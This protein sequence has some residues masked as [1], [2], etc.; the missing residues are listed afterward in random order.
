MS[1]EEN[2]TEVL[3]ALKLGL[4]RM[5]PPSIR[6]A[7]TDDAEFRGR[8][9]IT[10]DADLRFDQVGI[11]FRRSRLF[12]A[13]RRTY[14]GEDRVEIADKDGKNWSFAIETDNNRVRIISED[15][16][17]FLIPDF[18][19][20]SPRVQQRIEWFYREVH[21]TELLDS[22]ITSW[23]DVLHQRPA[24]DDEVDEILADFRDTPLSMIAALEDAFR[25]SSVSLSAL[26]PSS[27]RYYDR[28]I[29]AP[30]NCSTLKDFIDSVLA[31][32]FSKETQNEHFFKLFYLLASHPWVVDSMP[33]TEEGKKTIQSILGWIEGRSDRISQLGFIE[34][35]LQHIDE[36]PE[37]EIPLSRIIDDFVS[38]SLKTSDQKT[39]LLST[40]F[41][42]VDGELSKAGI[43]RDRPAFWRRL[44]SFAQASL[45]E[46]AAVSS[47]VPIEEFCQWVSDQGAVSFFVQTYV[48]MRTEPR[49]LPT[50]SSSK[51]LAT[52]FVAR[53]VTAGHKAFDKVKEAE[54]RRAIDEA[55]A[56]VKFPFSFLPG[57]LEGGVP[58]E[59]EIPQEIEEELRRAL[60]VPELSSSSFTVLVNAAIIYRVETSLA[61]LAADEL[62]RVKYQ[63]KNVS[64]AQAFALLSGLATVAAVTRSEQLAED[65]RVLMRV[66]RR[67]PGI[68]F[69]LE[70]AIHTALIS[71]GAFKNKLS[72][73][74][75]VGDC[76]TE[77]AL[78]DVTAEDALMLNQY[79]TILRRSEPTVGTSTARAAAACACF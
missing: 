41:V 71:A 34:W 19:C 12:G 21:S 45:I 44:A 18:S 2:G 40:L 24:T 68:K 75:F 26:V 20:L 31:A 23:R 50:F 6:S 9:G 67:T 55:R 15:G 32:R 8:L 61:V 43:C 39:T 33:I 5:F 48:D 72:W 7:A 58:P 38:D 78:G 25:H 56:R 27:L 1:S 57:P 63:L 37:V 42:L 52:E 74:K 22:S 60:E 51:Q 10:L 76:L 53:I 35:A 62:R 17:S 29:G 77:F 11:T 73:S 66:L 69:V 46:R 64:D 59:T 49:W 30:N 3:K 4:L 65:T 54:L 79:I 36:I 28:L 47:N 13:L 14:A 16:H 70:E